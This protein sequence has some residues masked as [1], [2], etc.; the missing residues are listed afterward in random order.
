MNLQHI[1]Y[2]HAIV[3]AKSFTHAA[4]NLNITQ[5][6][7][8]HS[9]RDLEQVL[10]VPLFKKKGRSFELTEFGY[11][12]Y[13]HA[14]T[15]VS[16]LEEIERDF[17]KLSDWNSGNIRIS[18]VANLSH[19]YI[20]QLVKDFRA[21]SKRDDIHFQ[22]S[23]MLATKKAVALLD[24]DLID[25]AFGAMIDTPSL[26]SYHICDERVYVIVPQESR[27]ARKDSFS[28]KSIRCENLVT[29]NSNCGTR[30]YI[31]HL[32]KEMDIVPQNMVE[33]ETEK[34]IASAVS[35]GLGVAIMPLIADIDRYKVKC[36]PIDDGPFSR[37]LHMMWKRDK[38]VR[39]VLREFLSFVK[40]Q[41][42]EGILL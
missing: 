29:Y 24:A 38:F 30:Y 20:P 28:L 26:C 3:Q 41:N 36:L 7:I 31:D 37:P 22:F 17:N 5:S 6:C 15:I 10:G 4:E 9:M 21:A 34:M 13:A 18:F 27:Y 16:E 14:E 11:A 12:F 40:S 39:P 25:V 42:C 19:N 8:S 1:I 2:F 33:V 23:E 35:S 32:L